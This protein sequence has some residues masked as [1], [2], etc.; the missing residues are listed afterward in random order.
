L[1]LTLRATD[2]SWQFIPA[3]G[4]SLTDAGTGQ[5]R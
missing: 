2:Y 4:S 1:M 3:S 5:C